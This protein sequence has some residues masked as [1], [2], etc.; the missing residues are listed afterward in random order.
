MR[1]LGW[2]G[3][4]AG[5]LGAPGTRRGAVAG[6]GLMLLVI[7]VA[8]GTARAGELGRIERKH[9]RVTLVAETGTAGG[10][11]RLTL[12]VVFRPQPG[13]HV[14]WINPG[15]SGLPPK[16]DWKMRD[17]AWRAGEVRFP[18]PHRIPVGPL[19]NYG[20]EGEA[21]LLIPFTRDADGDSGG[22][23]LAGRVKAYWLV[24]ADV[25]VPE[26]GE[27]IFSLAAGA[28]RPDPD[29]APL[30]R[31]ARAAMPKP[32]A[33][34]ARA[35]FSDDALVLA[36]PLPGVRRS[37]LKDA[38]FFPRAE[39]VLQYAAPQHWR[40]GE[41]RLVISVARDL[42]NPPPA[43]MVEGVLALTSAQ[44]F[45]EGLVIAAPIADDEGRAALIASAP[46]VERVGETGPGSGGRRDGG[47]RAAG[48]D[49]WQVFG[50]ALL[51]GLLLNLMP[52]V[53]PVLSMKAL[54]LLK[55][56]VAE[57]RAARRDGLFYTLGVMA[58]FL[59]L[60][61]LLLALKGA[62]AAVGWGFQLQNPVV[63]ALLALLMFVIGLDL[64]GWVR[65]GIA[66]IENVGAGVA[67]GEGPAG[68]LFTGVLA[69]VVATPCTAPFMAGALGAAVVMPWPAALGVFAGLGFGLAAPYLAISLSPGVRARLPRPGP[70][71]V[72]LKEFL[73]F[74]MWLT[75][76]WLVWV[77]ARE[78][79]ETAAALLLGAL[80]LVGFAAWLAR[81]AR[82][83][84][85][86]LLLAG[87]SV[88]GLL[89]ALLRLPVAERGAMVEAHG[90]APSP[91]AS[92][93]MREDRLPV[94]A[95]SR[96]RLDDLRAAGRP[97][98]VY[99]TADWCITCKVNEAVTLD[100]DEVIAAIR[101]KGVAVLEADWTRRDRAIAEELAR[102][103]RDGVPLYL[104]FAPGARRPDILPQILTPGA[105]IERLA[106]L[107]EPT[108]AGETKAQAEG[109]AR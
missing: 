29:V 23:A 103:G 42:A 68:A 96:R 61:G 85:L 27:I 36:V 58:S 89:L 56:G 99:F 9:T 88:A 71:M 28:G 22:R 41:G 78:A 79:G 55:A 43:G 33:L 108:A 15:D 101:R 48:A 13:W 67:G 16:F 74:P 45:R 5:V 47:A 75:A 35:A 44:D 66:G 86:P 11:D 2:A 17:H 70:W 83:R 6:F 93:T 63:V 60:G 65:L 49:W 52:C 73:A 109:D 32:L 20:Y 26:D 21:I 98:F 62:G 40:L 18:V 106:R 37:D 57:E 50:F 8:M 46:P 105:L 92:A 12:A 100:D 72:R 102:F 91:V 38:Y 69:T 59:M 14:Y 104:F 84:W 97:V 39:G 94:E 31:R 64:M 90:A 107:P 3:I 24:C 82:D 7:L 77:L 80:V 25:C 76:V 51:G 53:F 4:G 19:V 34:Q 1:T 30:F 95:W 81:V 87:L 54:S 10:E